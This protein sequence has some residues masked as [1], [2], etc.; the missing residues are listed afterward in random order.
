[1]YCFRQESLLLSELV[2]KFGEIG[3]FEASSPNPEG[4]TIELP[5]LE[6]GQLLKES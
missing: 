3:G 4:V 2:S 6:L 1:M 5:K